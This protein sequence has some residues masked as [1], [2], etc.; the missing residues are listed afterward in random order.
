MA[1]KAMWPGRWVL[2]ALALV[3]LAAM[4]LS[5]AH[6]QESAAEAGAGEGA[7]LWRSGDH[8]AAQRLWEESLAN[9]TDLPDRERARLAYNVGVAHHTAGEPLVAAAWFESA[10]RL[11]PRWEAAKANRDLS[12]ADAGLDPK[13]TGIVAGFVRL[14]TRG[15]A[16][17]LALLGGVLILV[18]GALDA[19]R[20][21]AWG[22]G[23]WLA[24][25]ALPVLWAPLVGQLASSNGE[26]AMVVVKGGAPLYGSPDLQGERLGKLKEGDETLVLDRLPGWVKVVDRGEERWAPED[27][28]LSLIR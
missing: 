13:D 1:S 4:L 2:R 22:R 28:V 18:L 7:R 26:V 14:F 12:R 9:G 20:G 10:L 25:L 15:E 24:I 8:D 11:A 27:S 3:G 16:E 19:F 23:P 5:G 17:W 6:A 21:G